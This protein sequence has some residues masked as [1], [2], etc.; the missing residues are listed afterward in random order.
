MVGGA[1]GEGGGRGQWE[2]LGK[3]G[4]WEGPVG[5]AGKER[6]WEEG[7]GSVGGGAGGEGRENIL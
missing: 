1:R 3:R 2:V 5:G 4:W 7:E 6:G